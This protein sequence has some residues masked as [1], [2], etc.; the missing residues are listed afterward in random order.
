MCLLVSMS[1][2]MEL[3]VAPVVNNNTTYNSYIIVRNDSNYSDITDL[4]GQKF[5]FSDPTSNAGELYP[6]YRLYLIEIPPPFGMPP[7]VVSKDIDPFPEKKTNG[8]F[9]GYEQ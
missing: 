8:D 3:L 9:P 5:A 6:A 7:I 1:S 4:S 2:I